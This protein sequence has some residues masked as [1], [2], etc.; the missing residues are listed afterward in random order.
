MNLIKHNIKVII[1]KYNNKMYQPNL[2]VK[3][4]HPDAKI[5]TKG[6]NYAAGYDIYSLEN[7][8]ILP[9][10]KNVVST[11]IS[12]RLPKIEEPY[13]IY[14]SIRSRSGLSVKSN[15]ETG[16][17]VI[18]LDYCGE[19]KIVL[20]NFGKEPFNYD[21][22]TRIAQLILEVHYISD[23]KEAMEFPELENH[24]RKGGFGSTGL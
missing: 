1:L 19:I 15:L 10:E 3:K 14:G 7:G 9:G 2:L 18:D 16:A 12:I 13:H 17:G 4:L 11:G 22:H 6:T 21:K 24:D 8:V 20:R 5:P 23:I